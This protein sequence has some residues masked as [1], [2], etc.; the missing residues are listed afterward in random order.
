MGP[1]DIEGYRKEEIEDE[2]DIFFELQE[3]ASK[4]ENPEKKIDE[5]CEKNLGEKFFS[6]VCV[7]AEIFA[8]LR[9][10]EIL[11]VSEVR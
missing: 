1:R 4:E 6:Q 7:E 9:K 3:N 10:T 5:I 11:I 2:K 8:L